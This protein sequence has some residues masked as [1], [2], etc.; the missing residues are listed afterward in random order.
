MSCEQAMIDTLRLK[1]TTS[2]LA[3]EHESVGHVEACFET[4][5]LGEHRDDID[6]FSK[7][8]Y[9]LPSSPW[10]PGVGSIATRR[11]TH[12]PGTLNVMAGHFG[13]LDGSPTSVC[14]LLVRWRRLQAAHQIKRHS[15]VVSDVVQL[16]FDG[17]PD[18]HRPWAWPLLLDKQVGQRRI[19]KLQYALR[20]RL[21]TEDEDIFSVLQSIGRRFTWLG[22]QKCL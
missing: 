11:N 19:T 6:R 16:S 4:I 10:A 15:R 5:S 14:P 7:T 21:D 12:S 8:P 17:I 22:Y 1:Y 2:T 18:Q 9:A 20:A 13:D 3:H